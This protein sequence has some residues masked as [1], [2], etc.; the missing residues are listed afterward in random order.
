MPG[1]HCTICIDPAKFRRAAEL[2]VEDAADVD[3]AAELG[4]GRMAVHR[5]R[6]NHVLML[7]RK[8]AAAAAKSRVV[9]AQ[10]T[11]VVARAEAGTLDPTDYLSMGTNHRRAAADRRTDRAD[12]DL[13]WCVA[14]RRW[15]PR[16]GAHWTTL[17]LTRA[18]VD[19]TLIPVSP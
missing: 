10:R 13:R 17:L 16:N 9:E 2:I 8:I 7:A 4:I 1:R 6:L 12:R 5:H 15:S 3:V 19:R 11:E 18:P 14:D